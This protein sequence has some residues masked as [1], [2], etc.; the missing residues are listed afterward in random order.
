MPTVE[1]HPFRMAWR[2][3]DLDAWTETL[4]PEIRVH[5]PLASA[6]LDGRATAREL[7]G[8]LFEALGE[9]EITNEYADTDSHAFFWRGDL[10]GRPIEGVV[11][12]RH[13]EHGKI[14]E[15][16]VLI[17]PLVALA[18]FASAIAPLLAAKRSPARGVLVRLVTLPLKAV[19]TFADNAASRFLLEH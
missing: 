9:V 12:L 2:T 8:I 19:V 3:R 1:E 16:R 11:R 5:S 6:P 7:F 4:S 18:A 15:M 13:D 10:G 14:A 17:R